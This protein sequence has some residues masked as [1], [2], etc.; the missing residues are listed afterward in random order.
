MS[1]PGSVIRS[2]K[3]QIYTNKRQTTVTKQVRIRS[4]LDCAGLCMNTDGCY[5]VNFISNNDVIC[6]LTTG[7]TNHNETVDDPTSNL[8]VMGKYS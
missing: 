3:F 6:E 4:S 5:A 1:F 2:R 8:Y 7:L